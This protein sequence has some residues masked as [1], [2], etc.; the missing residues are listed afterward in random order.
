[1]VFPA[2]SLPRTPI[3]GRND[4]R[5]GTP[6]TPSSKIRHPP[7]PSSTAR[8]LVY[9]L[10][11]PAEAGI[12]QF[13]TI[14]KFVKNRRWIL[15]HL[16]AGPVL[17]SRSLPVGWERDDRTVSVRI[18]GGEHRGRRL[19]VP[20]VRGLRPTTE[21]ARSAM[22]SVLGRDAVSGIRVLDAYA[23]TGVLG[24]ESLSR[25]AAWTDFVESHRRLAQAIRE[26]L[27]SLG[28]SDRARVYGY[29]VERAIAR[30]PGGYGLVFA[31]PP[32]G[33]DRWAGLM[34][35]LAADSVIDKG[36][37]PGGRAP[38]LDPAGGDVRTAFDGY[39]QAFRTDFIDLLPRR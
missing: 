18:A 6:S 2:Q 32:Y 20:D 12:H 29:R 21:V 10:V 4:E 37:R 22:F 34:G 1:M 39:E 23:G 11:I 31:D 35:R 7:T 36:G 19:R 5:S 3:R 16:I 28:M 9:A 33:M 13:F 27:R 25:G 24:M 26:N 15:L 17:P 8:R 14:L 30:L 38:G